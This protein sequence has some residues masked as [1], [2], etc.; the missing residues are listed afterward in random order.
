MILR[1][2]TPPTW[3]QKQFGVRP[4]PCHFE[5]TDLKP[6]PYLA[7]PQMMEPKMGPKQA[8]LMAN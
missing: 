7:F 4:L 2:V 3:I 1:Q 8:V 6:F 5:V